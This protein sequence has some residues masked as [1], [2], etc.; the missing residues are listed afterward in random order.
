[1]LEFIELIISFPIS[2]YKLI[3]RQKNT[4][5]KMIDAEARLPGL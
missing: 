2:S 4:V 3:I 1:M 5:F